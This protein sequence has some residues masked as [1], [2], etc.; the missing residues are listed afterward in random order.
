MATARLHANESPYPMSPLAVRA[1][2]AALE[3]CERYPDPGSP[4]LRRALA[5]HYRVDPAMV[6]V[7]SGSIELILAACRAWTVG[8]R[9][10]AVTRPGFPGYAMM[11]RL[12]GAPVYEVACD[13]LRIDVPAMVRALPEA[14]C[15]F[16]CNPLNPTGAVLEPDE[17]R[18]LVEGS[19]CTGAVLLIDEAYAEFAGPRLPSGIGEIRAG[20]DAIVLRTFSKAYGMAG[21][22]I[23]Y[24][25]GPAELIAQLGRW[26]APFS[27]SRPAQ[28][29]AA[30]ALADRA[31]LDDVVGRVSEGR[32]RLADGLAEL[33]LDVAGGHANFVVVS[34]PEGAAQLAA[35]LEAR[36][37]LVQDLA[38]FGLPGHI[39]ITVGTPAQNTALLHAM[40]DLVAVRR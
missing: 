3:R 24:A 15:A 1:A 25:I 18:A 5:E 21:L 40:A 13:G 8:R 16:V 6:A 27:V 28:A 23:G 32:R 38:E 17:L 36:S 12:A 20:G 19:N 7:G 2:G 10:V 4:D 11:A 9:P 39:R 30:A 14:G 37:L 29:A 33:G 35:G 31:Y 34:A 26:R 22:R